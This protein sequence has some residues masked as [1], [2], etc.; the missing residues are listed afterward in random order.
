MR[1]LGVVVLPPALDQQA[2]LGQRPEERAVE[3]LVAQFGPGRLLKFG[4]AACD[5]VM[6]CPSLRRPWDRVASLEEEEARMSEVA[7]LGIDLCKTS[8]SVV[9]MSAGG[10][11]VLRRRVA[12]DGI[13]ALLGKLPRCVVA[14]E[15]CCG[16]RRAAARTMSVVLRRRSGTRSG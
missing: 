10:R 12:R 14:M 11:V 2:G 9:G 5:Y 7:F 16:T 15:A 6:A 1:A 8:C 3:Q 4:P 13:S